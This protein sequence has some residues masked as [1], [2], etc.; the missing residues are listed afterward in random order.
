MEDALNALQCGERLARD[1]P[2]GV[3]YDAY[4]HCKLILFVKT[5]PSAGNDN[6]AWPAMDRSE[7]AKTIG[8][9]G[10]YVISRV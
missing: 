3:G 6:K 7:A 1:G 8:K 4:F 2:V 10:E 5:I 9:R